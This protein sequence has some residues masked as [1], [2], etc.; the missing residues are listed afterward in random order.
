LTVQPLKASFVDPTAT[1]R[2]IP[3]GRRDAA[4]CPETVQRREQE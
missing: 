2:D 1:P 4:D 3:V